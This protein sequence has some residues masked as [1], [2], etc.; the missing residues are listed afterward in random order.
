MPVGNIVERQ[1]KLEKA[2]AL[3]SRGYTQTQVGKAMGVSQVT[4]RE[5]LQ[6]IKQMYAYSIAD[7]RHDS[8]IKELNILAEVQKEAWEA[9][10]RSKSPKETVKES[11]IGTGEGGFSKTETTHESKV[12]DV[13]YLNVIADCV[14]QRRDILGLDAPK[15]V[16]ATVETL[17]WN[18]LVTGGLLT[19]SKDEVEEA[20]AAAMIGYTPVH[21][22]NGD[23][24]VGDNN[25]SDDSNDNDQGM[26]EGSIGVDAEP[27][28][29]EE[30]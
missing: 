29:S 26:G 4:A 25:R 14:K 20:I 6:Q 10:E 12:G 19:K 17:D 2:A 15:K 8:V 21:V 18:P 22:N 24:N 11:V 3:Y 16:H 1:K 9:W 27:E 7:K 23:S 13:Q 30:V 28:G 5:Y